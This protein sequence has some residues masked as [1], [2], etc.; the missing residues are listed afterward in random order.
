LGFDTLELQDS[1]RIEAVLSRH[2]V[3]VLLVDMIMPEKDGVEVIRD[4]R[5]AWPSL[6]IVAVSGGG[7]IGP[8]L[9]L[10]L[11]SHVGANA[12]LAKPFSKASLCAAVG[13]TALPPEH[14]DTPYGSAA[15]S[16]SS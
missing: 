2:P 1:R 4:V 8:E 5:A 7:A 13:Q 12:C 3:D 14:G 9:Y 16:R 10:D 6:R 11:A 15:S